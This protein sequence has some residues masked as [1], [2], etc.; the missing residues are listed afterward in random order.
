ML[1]IH[2]APA[3]KDVV[4][5]VAGIQAQLLQIRFPT[6]GSIIDEHGTVGPLG[7]SATYPFNLR[8]PH[9]GPF[10]S[11]KEFLEAHVR[12]ELSLIAD[13]NQWALQRARW[14][15]LNGGTDDMP[16]AYALRWFSLLLSAILA[17]PSE[18]FEPPH[19]SLSHDDFSLSNILVSPSG[20]V[21][22]LVDWQG[23]RICPLWND[24]RYAT[25]LQDPNVLE[26]QQELDSLRELHHD[27]IF[28]EIGLYP[29][30]SRLRLDYLLHITDY[31]YSVVASR[32]NLDD[33]FLDWFAVVV[34]AGYEEELQ[35]FL[36]LK[37]FIEVTSILAGSNPKA[38]QASALGTS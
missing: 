17:L 20:T 12:C 16:L 30:D 18:V 13:P 28:Q 2:V 9:R 33:L 37:Q 4:R 3:T 19:F 11:S 1:A 22:G 23:S 25:F 31:S 14:Q 26:D 35:P 15:N 6:I 21:T 36:A 7:L 38:N 32:A 24:A 10:A 34:S 8:D 5:Q 27:T 29:G